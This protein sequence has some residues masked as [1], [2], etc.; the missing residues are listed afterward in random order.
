MFITASA[1]AA[2]TPGHRPTGVAG[3]VGRLGR[4]PPLFS[5]AASESFFLDAGRQFVLAL[6][7]HESGAAG[8]FE[9]AVAD[10]H[11]RLAGAAADLLS[12]S[13]VGA[14]EGMRPEAHEGAILRLGGLMQGGA[15]AC[16]PE[17]FFT[18]AL[19]VENE[20][21]RLTI[22]SGSFPAQALTR[23]SDSQGAAA[24]F[25]RFSGARCPGATRVAQY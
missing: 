13:D 25:A 3:I 2:R 8:H 22:V 9:I 16:I 15:H 18:G 5:S 12:P 11:G 20:R 1:L 23:V 10:S 4:G 21:F 24:V 17:W 6:G 19:L 7:L 14:V